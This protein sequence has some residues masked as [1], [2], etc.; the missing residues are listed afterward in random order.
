M[1]N[2]FY[3]V[4][5]IVLA[6]L[7]ASGSVSMP[8]SARESGILYSGS[9]G[10]LGI[11]VTGEKA[12]E[13]AEFSAEEVKEYGGMNIQNLIE[14]VS[15]SGHSVDRIKS[16]EFICEE[17]DDI[18]D[19]CKVSVV[20]D[21]NWIGL[22]EAVGGS[23][24]EVYSVGDSIS[25][26]DHIFSDGALE[27]DCD[28]SA[29]YSVVI[30]APPMDNTGYVSENTG[31]RDGEDSFQSIE[32][33]DT[34]DDLQNGS[35][36]EYYVTP[37]LP[38]LHSQS[39][40]GTC[41]AFATTALAEISYMKQHPGESIDLSEAVLAVASFK[42]PADPLGNV[43]DI[44]RCTLSGKD[45]L[46]RGGDFPYGIKAMSMWYGLV[47]ESVAPYYRAAQYA[48]NGI[49]ADILKNRAVCLDHFEAFPS[50]DSNAIKQA[51]I[52]NGAVGFVYCDEGKYY[53]GT[54]NSYYNPDASFANHAVAIVGWDDNYPAENFKTRPQGNGAWLIRNS[55]VESS[56]QLF[57][58][59]GYFWI[60]YYDADFDGFENCYS[61]KVCDADGYDNN[62][63]YDGSLKST[64]T[65]SDYYYNDRAYSNLFTAKGDETLKA[66]SFEMPVPFLGLNDYDE[67]VDYVVNIYK[68][69]KF[70]GQGKIDFD[71]STKCSEATTVGSAPEN[72]FFVKIDLKNPVE[73]SKGEKFLVSIALPR[74][75]DEVTS[76]DAVFQRNM[77]IERS[78][79]ETEIS[80]TAVR[81]VA[82]SYLGENPLAASTGKEG[83]LLIKAYTADQG[84]ENI[85]KVSLLSDTDGTYVDPVFVK[86]GVFYDSAACENPVTSIT[87]P[88]KAG[89]VFRG[90]FDRTEGNGEKCIDEDGKIVISAGSIE[91]DMCLYAFWELVEEQPE[92]EKPEEDY[93]IYSG[94]CGKDNDEDLR[95]TIDAY[96]KLTI[97][98]NGRMKDY[99]SSGN[100]SRMAPW[101]I[102]RNDIRS[103]SIEEGV[104]SI[105]ECA[106]FGCE[107]LRGKVEIPSSV[108][109]VGGSAFNNCFNVEEVVF[110]GNDTT[111]GMGAFLHC[112][113]LKKV[114]LPQNLK[115]I[116]SGVFSQSGL[117]TINLPR[118][119]ESIGM[120]AFAFCENLSEINLW[121]GLKE[122]GGSAFIHTAMKFLLIPETVTSIGEGVASPSDC[123]VILVDD[124][125]PKYDSRN[126]CNAV[127]ETDSNT[128]IQGCRNTVIPDTVTGI[129][130]WAFGAS[131]LRS[132][133]V[134]ASVKTIGEYAFDCPDLLEITIRAS[135]CSIDDMAFDRCPDD[136]TIYGYSGSTAE[137]FAADH[138]YEFS[139]IDVTGTCGDDITWELQSDG[140]LV[141]SGTGPMPESTDPNFLNLW[142]ERKNEIKKVIIQEGVTSIARGAF[143]DSQKLESV[144]L[145]DSIKTIDELAF[146][147]CTN[148]TDINIPDGLENLGNY[149]F[150]NCNKLKSI[151]L[152][153][154]I[155]EIGDNTFEGCAE[156]EELIIHATECTFGMRAFYGCTKLSIHGHKG[157]NVETYA[158]E[159]SIPFV[160][161]DENGECG[162]NMHWIL[163][164]DGTLVISGSGAMYS[165]HESSLWD[166]YKDQI[167][168]VV[169]SEGVT[170]I[171]ELAFYDYK[172][173]ESVSLPDGLKNIGAC[174][175]SYCSSL[176]E[177]NIPDSLETIGNDAFCYC[178]MLEEFVAPEKVG[179]I[180]DYTFQGCSGLK[181]FIAG[182]ST[183][184]FGTKVFDGCNDLEI[185]GYKS[186]EAERY[187]SKCSIPFHAIDKYVISFD[188]N[189]GS[190]DCYDVT[191][192]GGTGNR[193]FPAVARPG[194]TFDGWFTEADGGEKIT[195]ETLPKLS[196]DLTLYAH[197]IFRYQTAEPVFSIASGTE[198]RAGSRV[199]LSTP[200][201]GAMIFY[202][203]DGTD[204][205][206]TN[207]TLFEDAIVIT[208]PV[209]IKAFAV[210]DG[211]ADSEVVSAS[212]TVKD[213]T[214]DWGDL[215]EEDKLLY[216]DASLIPDALWVSG[217]TD[218]DYIGRAITFPD[219]RVYDHKELLKPGRDYTVKYSDN[220]NAGKATVTIT[221]TGNF[222]GTIV[223]NFTINKRALSDGTTNDPNLKAPDITLTYSNKV[224]KEPTTVS[225]KMDGKW[226]VLKAGTDFTYSYPNEDDFKS[227][228][229]HKVYIIGKGNFTRTASFIEKI[230][231]VHPNINKLRWE[232]ISTQ[233]A[234]GEKI[235][236]DVCIKDGTYLLENKKDYTLEYMNNVLPGKAMVI[237]TGTGKYVGTKVLEFKIDAIPISK[238]AVTGLTSQPYTGAETVQNGCTLSYVFARN[239][240]AQ[241]L[242]EGTDYTVEYQN[243]I[244]AGKNKAT[245]IFTGIGRFT[246]TLKKTYTIDPHTIADNDVTPKTLGD[247]AYQK[248]KTCVNVVVMNGDIVLEEGK[249]YTLT[250]ENN[251]KPMAASGK[252]SAVTV[253]G[254]GNYTGSVTRV[255]QITASSLDNTTMTAADITYA[256]KA[257]ICKP[258]ITLYD[259]NGAKLAAG[260]DYEKAP[261]SFKYVRD[262]QVEHMDKSKRVTSEIKPEESDVDLANDIIPAGTEIRVTV[263]G[264]GNYAGSVKSAVFRF[265]RADLSKAAVKVTDQRYCGSDISLLKD[266]MT[267]TIGSGKNATVLAK[268]DYEIVSYTANRNKGTAEVALR[269][270]GDYGGTKTVKFKINAKSMNHIIIYDKNAADATGTMAV[271]SISDG[272][273]L[274]ANKFKRP[275][276]AFIGWSLT[277]EGDVTFADKAKFRSTSGKYGQ[278]I[279]LY[280]KWVAK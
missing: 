239:T 216:T 179:R 142:T 131:S 277:P 34:S 225:Y 266:Q 70:I 140:T 204:P 164:T 237:V 273:P 87:V 95:W 101:V 18:S 158:V 147:A 38:K 3:K 203:S 180:E 182:S 75:S 194:C 240:P 78:F 89:Y 146:G 121:S 88:E 98:G 69:V 210:M 14:D 233:K 248:G 35:F 54:T 8:A 212:Y 92:P 40:Y 272:K 258:V 111:I 125:N 178:G 36:E 236:P 218:K 43:N 264:A 173:L 265:V 33:N 24:L 134:P 61:L 183:C 155:T 26:I 45:L 124:K 64:L 113:E 117:E 44:T 144:R 30:T 31:E 226:T 245:I 56:A 263:R 150:G 85:Y 15:G 29:I 184:T 42:Q 238:A 12:S 11:T 267:V 58:H 279:T 247:V 223:K 241:P 104:S 262:V 106:F 250:Y 122:I 20:L 17:W 110:K 102:Y 220:T 168:K 27:F 93:V 278:T 83:N 224:Q 256:Q 186:S 191:V 9:V 39:P 4:M 185:Y 190:G 2:R 149:V 148:L 81:N 65:S 253:K 215:T 198:V 25:S 49:S 108:I 271:S 163:Q 13:D 71:H 55:W 141:I 130:P 90:Y 187:A 275:G 135:D 123:S 201:S 189:G 261:L 217:I 176:K 41:W 100:S 91:E 165:G 192:E 118:S 28:D 229:D 6:V 76:T 21:E 62:Y 48:N 181:K 214:A 127:I 174:A 119:L 143:F 205:D 47:P 270:L 206:R 115:T 46:N 59:Y 232:K 151:S 255:F 254:K 227:V 63:Q 77:G 209:T 72:E 221:G 242:T 120:G 114:V 80:S 86:N 50:D 197:W 105:G 193:A 276:Y 103:L 274:T 145:P 260:A 222:E 211:Y 67:T 136:L 53:D 207:G 159:N 109:S 23:E 129:G 243:N 252:R 219:L 249:D 188:P 10:E 231:S 5:S 167:K 57:S 112:Y 208:G 37:N 235:E 269:G 230:D 138:G 154:K 68:D 1:N 257:G 228:G 73:L 246:G 170:S 16:F 251:T 195:D 153:E 133:S 60:S 152:P 244:D 128:L 157:T 166:S 172:N 84:H 177:I 32:D 51:I 169:I 116:E 268:T 259:S 52:D 66:V 96:G 171:G 156:L 162:D 82:Q 161:I 280:A 97:S 79:S 196:T 7:L 19:T 22:L 74:H 200:T 202:T 94:Y 234:S 137:T 175:F 213:E 132:I 126:Y 107:Q 160:P 199:S 139:S 99:Q